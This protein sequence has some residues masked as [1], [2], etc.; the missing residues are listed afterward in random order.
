MRKNILAL[1]IAAM[2]GGIGFT[3]GASAYILAGAV[4]TSPATVG[5]DTATS[6]TALTVNTDGIGHFLVVPYYSVRNGNNTYINLVNTDQSFGKAVKVRFRGAANSDDVFDFQVFLSPGD[7]WSA[8]VSQAPDGRARLTTVDKSCTLPATVNGS[9]VLDRLPASFTFE[10]KAIQTTEGYVEIFNMADIP[11]TAYAAQS[12]ATPSIATADGKNPLFVAIKHV[13]GVAPCTAAVLARL[14][15]DPIVHDAV[16]LNKTN[17]A[18]QGLALPT[19]GLFANWTII[20]VNNTLTYTGQA[21]AIQAVDDLSTQVA[22]SGRLVFHP[23]LPTP[24]GT[25]PAANTRTTDP[26]LVGGFATMADDGTGT[27]V[28]NGT[29]TPLYFDFPDFSTPYTGTAALTNLLPKAQAAEIT[30]ALA[31]TSVNNE[32]LTDTSINAQTDWVFSS[33]TRR[34]SVG[35]RYDETPFTRVFASLGTAPQTYFHSGNTSVDAGL[36]QICVTGVGATNY[37][38]REERVPVAGSEFVISPGAC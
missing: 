31:V 9:F 28:V 17:A 10:Q 36:S 22:G 26:I 35:L 33:P 3:G 7:H 30:R 21:T 32:Y 15:T 12:S 38:D 18:Y 13:G 37:F 4:N 23:Q 27:T 29:V 34:Y 14:D 2:V 5:L 6:S 8:N 25:G 19:T 1:S 16:T 24:I 20:N 11:E